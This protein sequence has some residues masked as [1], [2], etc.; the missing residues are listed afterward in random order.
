M[1]RLYL[2][3]TELSPEIILSPADN[4]FRITGRSSPE[5]V[6]VLY[7]P[8][9]EWINSFILSVLENKSNQY[10]IEKPLIFRFEFTYF[11]SSSA[12]FLYDILMDL[13][14][15]HLEN[16]PLII[17][18]VYDIEDIDMKEAG[19]DL[20]ILSEMEFTYIEIEH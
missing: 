17:E 4:I 1:E 20:A 8:V 12:K 11:N 14:K 2:K 7:Y 18:W 16:V 19:M 10:S 9:I 13:R 5:D 6:R 3:P 15:L